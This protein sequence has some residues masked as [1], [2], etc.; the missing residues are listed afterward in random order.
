[1]DSMLQ[2]DES[3]CEFIRDFVL[4]QLRTE[5]NANWSTFY[6]PNLMDLPGGHVLRILKSQLL[7]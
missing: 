6:V 5:M 7:F 3:D 1:M 4:V 2:L